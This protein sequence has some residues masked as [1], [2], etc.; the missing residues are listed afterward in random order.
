[1]RSLLSII[2]LVG[3]CS[4][5]AAQWPMEPRVV[6]GIPIG[7]PLAEA[8]LPQCPPMPDRGFYDQ[9]PDRL[10]VLPNRYFPGRTA[11][12]FGA[13]NLGFTYQASVSL[14]NGRIKALTLVTKQDQFGKAI[15]VLTERYGQPSSVDVG[16]VVTR[17]G[18][19]LSN[20]TVSW[21][22]T[23]TSLTAIERVGRIDESY[24]QFSD[25]A[26]L[27]EAASTDADKNKAA[28]SKL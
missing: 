18:A 23:A 9:P 12:I 25:N 21:K 13:P 26:L 14:Q 8:G 2:Y 19:R 4:I 27:N 28:A 16:E 6:M 24:I 5:A 1:M 11:D 15:A 3:F 7:A 20:R 10:C 22:G 17:M